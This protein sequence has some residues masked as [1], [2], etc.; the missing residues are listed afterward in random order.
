M[1][2]L[3]TRNSGGRRRFSSAPGKVL[4]KLM[5]FL[6]EIAKI[7]GMVGGCALVMWLLHQ[8]QLREYREP[9]YHEPIRIQL[10]NAPA[11]LDRLIRQDLADLAGWSWIDG[12]VCRSV[13]D[14]LAQS[15]WIQSIHRVTKP[16]PGLVRVKCEYRLPIALVQ[17][18]EYFYMVDEYGVR[19]PGQHGY[20]PGWLLIQGVEGKLPN[21]GEL[22]P[23]EDLAAGVRLANMIIVQPYRDQVS[24]VLVHNYGGRRDPYRSHV[25]LLTR[26]DGHRILWGSAPGEE[27]EENSTDQ[28]LRILAAN[29]QRY[30]TIDADQPTIDISVLPDRFLIPARPAYG[31]GTTWTRQH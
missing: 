28:K 5:P 18:R 19:L 24:A 20:E 22:W 30:G 16:E 9:K 12:R 3:R 21:P 1:S 17:D 4:G 7:A 6:A 29:Y 31:S 25:E 8:A 2:A 10:A 23:G 13:H 26:R 15:P 14:R 27:L 11:G